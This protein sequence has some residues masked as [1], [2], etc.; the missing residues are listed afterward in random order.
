VVLLLCTTGIS[1]LVAWAEYANSLSAVCQPRMTERYFP[2]HTHVQHVTH[3][4][5]AATLSLNYAAAPPS[6]YPKPHYVPVIRRTQGRFYAYP[7]SHPA[8]RLHRVWTHHTDHPLVP[9]AITA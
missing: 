4:R 5:A 8:Q 6:N 1:P 2:A 7:V 3:Q 9:R